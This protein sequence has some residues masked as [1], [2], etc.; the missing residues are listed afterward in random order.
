MRRW[1]RLGSTLDDIF[2]GL[3]HADVV[4]MNDES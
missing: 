2:A 3:I 1:H 4:N